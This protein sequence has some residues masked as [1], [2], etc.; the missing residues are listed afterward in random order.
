[1]TLLAFTGMFLFLIS[2]ACI[3]L[4]A[5][6]AFAVSC[7]L[8]QDVLQQYRTGLLTISVLILSGFVFHFS[9]VQRCGT[10]TV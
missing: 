2:V 5:A 4:A 1:L 3:A 8:H 9:A 10:G 7:S 6:V